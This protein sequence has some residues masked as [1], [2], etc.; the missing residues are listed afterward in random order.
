MTSLR[1][2]VHYKA[3]EMVLPESSDVGGGALTE[4]G[5]FPVFLSCLFLGQPSHIKA[6][7]K[8]ARS[9]EDEDFSAF[10]FVC[11]EM[12]RGWG[13]VCKTRREPIRGGSAPTSCR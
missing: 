5:T 13:A 7:G 1:A 12:R 10:L 4:L 8:L 3:D 11:F 2:S 9:G 6:T